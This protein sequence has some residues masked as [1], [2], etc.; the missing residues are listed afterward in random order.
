M[1]VHDVFVGTVAG[2]LGLVLVAAAISRGQWLMQLARA[3]MLAAA[4]GETGARVLIGLIGLALLALG[5][6]IAFGW[7]VHWS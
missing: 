2:A 3:R 1:A 5:A 7:R 6:A 4:L